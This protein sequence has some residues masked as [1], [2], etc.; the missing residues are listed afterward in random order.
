[1]LKL[2]YSYALEYASKGKEEQEEGNQA[3]GALKS[4]GKDKSIQDAAA[5]ATVYQTK[6]STSL[7]R[8]MG[9]P[10]VYGDA[11]AT[12]F[13]TG[14]PA[15]LERYPPSVNEERTSLTGQ[16]SLN[17]SFK[18]RPPKFFKVGRVLMLLWTEPAGES[19]LSSRIQSST[20]ASK[21]RVYA[22][23]RRFIV[24]AQ[25]QL[26]V[27]AVPVR[28]YKGM[29][30][31]VPKRRIQDHGIAYMGAQAPQPLESEVIMPTPVRI[32]PDDPTE[33]LPSTSRIDYGKI[34]TIE[35]NVKCG[36]V[37]MVHEASLRALQHQL[38][39]VLRR[40]YPSGGLVGIPEEEEAGA[41]SA[42]VGSDLD[43]LDLD[44]EESI[45]SQEP[46][47]DPP[48]SAL[49]SVDAKKHTG[50]GSNSGYGGSRVATEVRSSA[51]S[52]IDEGPTERMEEDDD[53]GPGRILTYVDAQELEV[54]AFDP[55]NP[56]P[57][58][59]QALSDS[60]LRFLLDSVLAEQQRRLQTPSTS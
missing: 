58:Q 29:G 34:Y 60:S 48:T 43:V 36:A 49:R 6:S 28:S 8:Y 44:I 41:N 53:L 30:A 19:A 24:V 37:G 12:V 35:T 16:Q 5:S 55:D 22:K 47:S 23:I 20:D 7:E 45:G 15:R 52:M 25:M 46:Q 57:E 42:G 9:P 3:V 39:E 1:M 31:D 10:P 32:I 4:D 51:S 21:G 50:H 27:L 40:G 33:R 18:L 2:Q 11:T 56:S 17:A 38:N 26:H 13:Q 54:P 14:S 59:L